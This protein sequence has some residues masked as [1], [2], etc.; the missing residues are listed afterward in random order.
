L[1]DETYEFFEAVENNDV[2]AMREEL[3]D[4][5]LQV[6]LH[7]QI[8]KDDGTFTLDD[9]AKDINTKL[10]RRHPH[11][12]GNV[13]VAS[14]KEVLKNW[15]AIK[16][17][18]KKHRK[19]LVDDIPD[20]LPALFRAE[21]IQRRVA[22]AGFDWADINPVLDKVEEEFQEFREAVRNN[23]AQNAEEEL[24]DILFALVNV[25]RHKKICAEDALRLTIKKF[26]RRFSY[27]EDRYAE[28]G[29]DI[30]KATLEDLDT[31]WEESKKTVG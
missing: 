13:E 29:R 5:L 9:V 20:A 18:E 22:R 30:L 19:Y 26:A 16:K 10:I 15:E 28:Q 27:I 6:V 7:A 21:K 11:V 14:T 8:A 25:A 31:Y 2:H 17:T 23:D 4:L 12:F 1:L 3:G 24:G